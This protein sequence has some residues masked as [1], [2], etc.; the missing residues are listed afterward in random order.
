MGAGRGITGIELRSCV[1]EE[2][3]ENAEKVVKKEGGASKKLCLSFAN[4]IQTLLCFGY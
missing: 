1:L 2:W 4:V 3:R